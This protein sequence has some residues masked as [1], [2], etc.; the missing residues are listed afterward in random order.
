[1]SE[2]AVETKKAPGM[3]QL[4]V[5]LFAICTVCALLLGL[6][7]FITADKIVAAQAA[8]SQAA[9]AT[10]LPADSYE[11]V[12]YTGG[13]G[14]ILSM[15]KAG[16]A[17]YVVEVAC[18]ASFSGTLN[19]MVGVGADGNVTGV[20]VVKSSETSGLGQNADEAYFKDQFN[21]GAGPF[22]V[23]KDGGTIEAITGAT[24]SSRAVSNGV[25]SALDAV[26]SLG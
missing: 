13:D 16:D 26:A 19:I 8:K 2:T 3:A 5:T 4:T 7:N 24:I 17:G 20:K 10:V 14:S 23:T 18:P 9:M 22:K 1:M 6:V 21:G 25:N 12:E 11:P 15:N